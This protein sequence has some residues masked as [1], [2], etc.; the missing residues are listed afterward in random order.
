M[1]IE[2]EIPDT[3]NTCKNCLLLIPSPSRCRLYRQ[4]LAVNYKYETLKCEDCLTKIR[5][6]KKEDSNESKG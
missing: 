5:N 3:D 1:K 4:V 2:I 6:Y